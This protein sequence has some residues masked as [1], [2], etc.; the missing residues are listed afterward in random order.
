M[1]S[2]SREEMMQEIAGKGRTL[3]STRGQG[4]REDLEALEKY[5][6]EHYN[7]TVKE[8]EDLPAGLDYGGTFYKVITWHKSTLVPAGNQYRTLINPLS[9][10]MIVDH[11]Q[12]DDRVEKLSGSGLFPCSE[13]LYQQLKQVG[14]Q[15]LTQITQVGVTGGG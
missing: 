12:R 2:K 5:F 6:I 9:G 8:E 4:A 14:A 3:Y 7:T 1:A 10:I 13:I 11:L 15:G